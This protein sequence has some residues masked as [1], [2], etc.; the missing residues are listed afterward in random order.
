M[1][2]LMSVTRR[3]AFAARQECPLQ[4]NRVLPRQVGFETGGNKPER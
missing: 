1:I 2:F 4:P 3:V